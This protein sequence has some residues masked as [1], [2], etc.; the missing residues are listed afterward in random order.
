MTLILVAED[1]SHIRLLILRKLEGANYKV[2]VCENGDE[3]LKFAL[4]KLPRLLLLDIMMP[5]LTGLQVCERVKQQLG[6]KAPRVII[7][8]ARGEEAD[9]VAAEKAGADDYLIKPFSPGEMLEH[10]KAVLGQS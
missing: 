3:A 7:V 8:S 2:I 5:G 10:V 1:D 4:E 9:V 6:N